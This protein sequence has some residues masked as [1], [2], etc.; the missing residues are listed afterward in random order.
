MSGDRYK[1]YMRLIKN[2]ILIVALYAVVALSVFVLI[3]H[4]QFVYALS[5]ANW[6][7][8]PVMALGSFIAGSTCLGGGAVAFPAMTKLMNADPFYART[9]SLAIQSIG[10]TSASLFILLRVRGLPWRFIVLYLLAAC[11]GISISFAL[12]NERV[13]PAD[14]RIMFTIFALSFLFIYLKTHR[15]SSDLPVIPKIE[16]KHIP[17]I[18]VG[19][20]GGGILSGLLGSG[21]DLVAFSILVLYFRLNPKLATQCS[22]VIMAATSIAGIVVHNVF[23]GGIP[24]FVLSLWFIAVPVVI[25]GAPVGALFC[26]Y[27]NNRVLLFIISSLII[28]ESSTTLLLVPLSMNSLVYYALFGSVIML[29]LHLLQKNAIR[30]HR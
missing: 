30:Q 27:I 29:G 17:L 18:L 9:F 25:I 28:I 13:A 1:Q 11:L 3:F 12:F 21:A 2:N 19:G 14:V 10:M 5:N 23:I 26:H 4:R 22:V 24:D 15:I 20:I 8:A 16:N 7:I 6:L